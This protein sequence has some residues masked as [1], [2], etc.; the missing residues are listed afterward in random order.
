MIRETCYR[1]LMERLRS[2]RLGIEPF[3][4]QDLLRLIDQV[5]ERV[6]ARPDPVEASIQAT[7][8]FDQFLSRMIDE[9]RRTN[10]QSLFEGTL[11][12]ARAR[13]GILFWCEV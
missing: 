8:G 9:A 6:N 7:T 5:E 12:A 4:L 2:A 3:C 10:A 13:C 11:A 1:I